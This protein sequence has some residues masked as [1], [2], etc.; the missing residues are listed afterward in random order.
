MT[1]RTIFLDFDKPIALIVPI[2][3]ETAVVIK[4]ITIVVCNDSIIERF[5]NIR[6]YQIVENPLKCVSDLLELKENTII[7]KI[8]R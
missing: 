1:L 2:S 3:V 6:S 7:N 8:G 4:A 5:S